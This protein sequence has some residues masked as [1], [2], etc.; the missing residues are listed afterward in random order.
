MKIAVAKY[1][2]FC[3]GVKRAVRLTKECLKKRGKKGT[4][5]IGPL[6]H[7]KYVVSDLSKEGLEVKK[8]LGG[9]KKSYC[10]IPSHGIDASRLKKRKGV[11]FVDTT[12]PFVFK[13]QELVKKLAGSGYKIFI[14]GDKDHP[15][16]K[17][18]VGISSGRATVVSGR[19]TVKKVLNNSMK[20]A[21]FLSQTTQSPHNFCETASGLIRAGFYELRIFNTICRDVVKRQIEAQSLAKDAD[22]MLVIGG[23]NSANTKRLAQITQNFAKTYHIESEEE[24]K[25]NWFKNI[26]K[27]GIITG[28]S[29]PGEFIEKVKNQIKKIKGGRR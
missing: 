4:C 20:K 9:I 2:G 3:F 18:L 1:S 14:L 25:K 5:S 16:V 19:K 23:K 28:A 11:I 17:G 6:I 29:T 21:A 24:I 10:I 7:N 15:E 22:L 8:S 26:R 27:V 12:C 13:A